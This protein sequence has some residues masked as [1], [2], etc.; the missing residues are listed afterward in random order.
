MSK[1]VT[2]GSSRVSRP[3]RVGPLHRL[4]PTDGSL[5]TLTGLCMLPERV[6]PTWPT[7]R[8]R[9]AQR[10]KDSPRSIARGIGSRAAQSRGPLQPREFKRH[11]RNPPLFTHSSSNWSAGSSSADCVGSKS[12][13]Y[14][15]QTNAGV[16][17]AR[18]Q[19]NC[20]GPNRPGE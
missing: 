17:E 1:C 10:T 6:E 18:L 9:P 19:M 15:V 4:R 16:R 20:V 14:D 13:R 7:G 2:F 11:S 5:R 8:F 3:G 12:P